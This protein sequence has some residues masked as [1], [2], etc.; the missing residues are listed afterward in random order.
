VRDR[1]RATCTGT[2]TVFRFA[3]SDRVPGARDMHNMRRAESAHTM[4]F[5]KKTIAWTH[6]LTE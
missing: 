6:L 5:R 4:P 2:R 1:E 3:I